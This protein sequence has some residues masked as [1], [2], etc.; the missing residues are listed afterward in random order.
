[1]KIKNIYTMIC[2]IKYV[3]TIMVKSK[4]NALVY[5][6]ANKLIQSGNIKIKY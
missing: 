5:F 3:K 6:M 2:N 1:M 4:V